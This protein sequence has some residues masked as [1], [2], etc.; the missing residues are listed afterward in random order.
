MQIRVIFGAIAISSVAACVADQALA[1]RI[2]EF[3][4]L[5]KASNPNG[6]TAGQD[7]ALWFTENSVS[8]IGRITTAGV[9][10]E[11]PTPTIVSGPIGITFDTGRR[12]VVYRV[13]NAGRDRPNYDRGCSH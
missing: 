3:P 12:V 11:F 8:Q 1:K 2:I 5:T 13:S 10:T 4:I 6:I 9:V 7:G